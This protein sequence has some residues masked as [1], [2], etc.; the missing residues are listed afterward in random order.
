MTASA[1]DTAPE[2]AP[3]RRNLTAGDRAVLVELPDLEHALGLHARLEALQ[4]GESAIPGVGE[5]MPAARTLLVRF[6]PARIGRAQL[7]ERLDAVSAEPVERGTGSLVEIP[8]V[9]DGEDLAE[10]AAHLGVSVEELVR[11]HTGSAYTVAFAGFAPGFAYLVGGD[12]LLDVPR[13]PTPRTRIPA[14]SVALAGRFSGVYPRESPG[15]WQLIGT[16]P[17]PMWDVDRDP[18]AAMRPGDRVRFVESAA[19]VVETRPRHGRSST[20][21]GE[22]ALALVIERAGLRTLLQDAGRPGLGP[23]GVAESGILDAPAMRLA[24]RLVGGDPE[25]AVLEIPYGGLRARARGALVVAVTGARVPVTVH[26]GDAVLRIEDQRAVALDDGD[27]IE[28]G[29]P[30]AGMRA[31]LAVRGGF[32]APPVLGSLATDTLAGLGPEPIADGDVLAVRAPGIPSPAVGAPEPWPEHASEELTVPI[33]LGPR[34]D[35]FDQAAIRRLLEQPWTIT[36]HADRVGLRLEGA[37]PLDRLRDGEL[38]SEG[39]VSGSIQVPPSGQP[40]VFLADHPITGG[41]PIIGVV[42]HRALALLAQ[43]APGLR[44]RFELGE[45]ATAPAPAGRTDRQEL[46]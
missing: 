27:R 15:G 5:L 33:D 22:A 40:M 44:L 1:P 9:Y 43:A 45:G 42:R 16:T 28:L 37:E 8:V 46:P 24:N 26:R 17:M 13:R 7:L 25:Q 3:E 35:W 12:P 18:P 10:M 39:A 2:A 34:D 23:L 41:Y 19:P 36:A 6:D 31:V 4:A 30:L 29:A 21:E 38:P 32:D 11:R 20:S 14:G